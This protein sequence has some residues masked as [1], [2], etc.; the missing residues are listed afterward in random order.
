[1]WDHGGDL[2]LLGSTSY[3]KVVKI[4]PFGNRDSAT[5]IAYIIGV[6]TRIISTQSSLQSI[7]ELDTSLKYCYYVYQVTVTKDAGNYAKGRMNGQLLAKYLVV[8]DILRKKY[9]LTVDVHNNVG[10]W[11]KTRFIFS[12]VSGTKAETIARTIKSKISWLS[13]FYPPNPTSLQYVTIPL[14]KGG[15]PAVVFEVYYYSPYATVYKEVNLV[16]V[17]D[18]LSY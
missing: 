14:I 10:N 18:S 16:G 6:S 17:V 15:V 2:L 4:G 8:P 13:Y 3:G 9:T 12:P 11:A 5:K 1:M 7:K